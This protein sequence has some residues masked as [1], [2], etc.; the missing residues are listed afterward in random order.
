MAHEINAVGQV[1]SSI[2]KLRAAHTQA[3]S[4][5]FS[6]PFSS[7]GHFSLGSVDV[8][9]LLAEGTALTDATNELGERFFVPLNQPESLGRKYPHL[10]DAFSR[11]A[12]VEGASRDG[13]TDRLI[14]GV[15][16]AYRYTHEPAEDGNVSL[17]A[18]P[19]ID[20]VPITE[21]E[22]TVVPLFTAYVVCDIAPTL[23]YP[24]EHSAGINMGKVEEP[25]GVLLCHPPYPLEQTID[26]LAEISDTR[27]PVPIIAGE[28]TGLI[29]LHSAP[30]AE[31]PIERTLLNFEVRLCST[32]LY[33]QV[34]NNAHY[35]SM[36]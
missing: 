20:M 34:R 5:A 26:R 14:V 4:F 17:A 2:A 15:R 27:T 7:L 36:L 33:E 8:E 31:E 10:V 16:G 13:N 1:D 35:P 6:K 32:S 24:Q 19:H 11:I 3:R 12:D 22:G 30:L 9:A 23:T 29:G 21:L 25:E 28:L 18:K